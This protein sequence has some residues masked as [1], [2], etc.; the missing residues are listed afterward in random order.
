VPEYISSSMIGKVK[1]LSNI[2]A[3]EI[4]PSWCRNIQEW[5]KKVEDTDVGQS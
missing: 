3:D 2:Y 5:N 4:A 1:K